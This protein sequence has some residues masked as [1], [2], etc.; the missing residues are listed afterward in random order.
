[1]P[2]CHLTY[3]IESGPSKTLEPLLLDWQ[4]GRGL[5]AGD[6]DPKGAFITISQ[7]TDAFYIQSPRL[8]T[9]FSIFVSEISSFAHSPYS[10]ETQGAAGSTRPGWSPMWRP[11]E[12]QT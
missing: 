2:I 10:D 9:A 5:S 7:R 11:G 8:Q 1:M 6:E 3:H 12:G 4:G